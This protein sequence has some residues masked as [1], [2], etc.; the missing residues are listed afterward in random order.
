MTHHSHLGLLIFC[1][2][3]IGAGVSVDFYSLVG[4][5][6]LIGA[7]EA[8]FAGLAPTFI[9]DIAPPKQRSVSHIFVSF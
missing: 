3:A 7:G 2:A 9:D 4:S 5:R 1:I 8:S 6:L